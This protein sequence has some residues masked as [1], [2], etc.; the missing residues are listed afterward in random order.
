[1]IKAFLYNFKKKIKIQKIVIEY[2][3]IEFINN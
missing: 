3:S 2:K 1:M